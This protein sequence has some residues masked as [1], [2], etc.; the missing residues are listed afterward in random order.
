MTRRVTLENVYRQTGVMPDGLAVPPVPPVFD[1]PLRL[2]QEL[3][4]GRDA[5]AMGIAPLGWRDFAAFTS[6]TGERLSA[7][8]L[9]AVRVIEDEFFESRAAAEERRQR[10]AKGR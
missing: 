9:E 1:R 6:V 8:D 2:W 7:S 10:A 4:R 5:G 3:H